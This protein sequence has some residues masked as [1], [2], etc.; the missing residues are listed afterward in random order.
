DSARHGQDLGQ[1]Q[2]FDAVL[3]VLCDVAGKRTVVVLVEDLH[4]AD[5]STRALLS[6]VA[7]RL[8]PCR[9]LLAASYR[10]DDVGR[11]HPL[12]TLLAELRRLDSVE[13]LDLEPLDPV[14]ARRLVVELTGGELDDES[15]R[16]L[17]VRGAG[18]PF[19]TEELAA[20]PAA[21]SGGDLPHGLAELLLARVERLARDTRLVVRALS[22]ADG[23]ASHAALADVTGLR[24][25]ELD[26]V[27]RS[28]V[29]EHVLVVEGQYYGFRH[30]LL[31]EAVYADLMPGERVR[32]HA[33]Y[34]ERLRNNAPERGGAALLAYHSTHSSDLPTAL[35]ASVRAAEEAGEW[36][37]APATALRMADKA[38]QVWE[39]VSVA[40][41]PEGVDELL[42]LT[43]AAKYASAAGQPERA[44]G[45]SRMATEA[46]DAT[47]A[48]QR[49]ATTWRRLA[50]ALAFQDDTEQEAVE[51]IER[52]W[53]M[54]IDSDPSAVRARVLATR[55]EVMRA[56]GATSVASWS[57][58]AA[59]ADADAAGCPEA[60]IEA[61]I[62]MA[63]LVERA[64]DLDD[65][66]DRLWLAR[67]R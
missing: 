61:Q 60:A 47:V 15:V 21:A 10:T 57:A 58:R 34:A 42:L 4:W 40:Q 31:R 3:R 24:P 50:K 6:F 62:T 48:E 38:L 23:P 14:G 28:A 29:H 59:L 11:T 52:A 41:R 16:R 18:N 39:A 51:S 2:L 43:R 46:L 66:R 49:A 37:G 9:L 5:P 56:A 13:M 32:L 17:V 35:Q 54:V 22:V 44:V 20:S 25:L 27:L 7:S 45:Y 55:A 53:N 26:D 8:R 65:A 67:R 19:F 1:L 30:A 33:R 64:G 63:V 36:G 12:R